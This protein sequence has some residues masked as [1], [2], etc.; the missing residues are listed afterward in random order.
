[1]H[2]WRKNENLK[3]KNGKNRKKTHKQKLFVVD[4]QGFG[5]CL[6]N[7]WS[8][9]EPDRIPWVSYGNSTIV[10]YNKNI[11]NIWDDFKCQYRFVQLEYSFSDLVQYQLMLREYTSRRFIFFVYKMFSSNTLKEKFWIACI[12]FIHFWASSLSP[13]VEKFI[14]ASDINGENGWVFLFSFCHTLSTE[15]PWTWTF[16]KCLNVE[17]RE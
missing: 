1:M 5:K 9:N 11:W 17:N 12:H 7:S 6:A 3:W 8:G 15:S 13:H 14:Q 10:A 4:V 16:W 2:Y